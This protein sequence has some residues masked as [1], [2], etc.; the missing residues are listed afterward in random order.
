MGCERPSKFV[1]KLPTAVASEYEKKKNEMTLVYKLADVIKGF[2]FGQ[3]LNAVRGGKKK[4]E[5]MLNMITYF[6]IYI[7]GEL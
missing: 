3:E 2:T 5:K 6:L 4:A 7:F 1:V